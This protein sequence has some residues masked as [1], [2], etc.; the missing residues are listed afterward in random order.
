MILFKLVCDLHYIIC[1][2]CSGGVIM[3]VLEYYLNGKRVSKN[4][5]IQK[6]GQSEID[7]LVH[8]VVYEYERRGATS[9]D[10]AN[11]ISIKLS[12]SLKCAK[13]KK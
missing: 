3:K 8:N 1:Y 9:L 6:F 7:S 10:F 13:K 4:V 2:I 11:N 12:E 5:L